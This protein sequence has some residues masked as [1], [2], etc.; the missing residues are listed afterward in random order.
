MS[1]LGTFRWIYIQQR[2]DMHNILSL[3]AIFIA[4]LYQ[5]PAPDCHYYYDLRAVINTPQ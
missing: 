3:S 2:L 5:A 1:D 4:L